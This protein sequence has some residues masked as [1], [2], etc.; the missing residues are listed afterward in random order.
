MKKL[1]VAHPWMG[2]GGSEATAMWT[3]MALQDDYDVTFVTAS[4]VDWD[5]LN[6]AYGTSVNPDRVRFLRAP[7]LPGVDRAD[8]LAHLQLRWFERFCQRVADDFDL[9]LSAYHPIWFGRP[10]VQLIGDFSFSEKMRGLLYIHGGERF[11]HR[12]TP[13]RRAYLRL[14]E[15]I[16][17]E[18]PPL[19]QR[20]DLVLAN[21]EWSA[22]QL[23]EHFDVAGAPI[24]YP[25]VILP[26][27]PEDPQ[28]EPFSFVCLGRVVPEKELERIFRI[29]EAVRQ[30]GYP[31]T[32]RMIG[33]LDESEYS[34]RVAV[35]IDKRDWITP[36]GFLAVEM[37]QSILA[38]RRFALHA[39]RIEAFGIA[40]AEM[41]S[42][43]C[44]PFVPDSGGAG[45]I[46]G[47][48]ELQ[49]ADEDEAVDKIVALLEN[50]DREETLRAELIGSMDR[51]GP[52]AFMGALR[53]H[54]ESFPG[55][56]GPSRDGLNTHDGTVPE[57]LAAIL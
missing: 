53:K 44:V 51:F 23:E 8:R 24:L 3:L 50:P 9:C 10:G 40:V 7:R 28:R 13:L 39:C 2:R 31:I 48:P 54:V 30:R 56:T 47:F 22:G 19:S 45:E 37:K 16:G 26:E 36:E 41:A 1:L 33:A 11:V 57:N 43:G 52:D 15:W 32:L 25:P 27:A 20:G 34:R 6:A 5:D 21:S 42:M 55:S 17:R 49:F 14:C 35:E 18:A 46:V 38:T 29:L 4:P 12:T